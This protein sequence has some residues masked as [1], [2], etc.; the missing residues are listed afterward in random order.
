MVARRVIKV[1]LG[2]RTYDSAIDVPRKSFAK[3]E[4]SSFES[5]GDDVTICLARQ[6]VTLW[7]LANVRIAMVAVAACRL[8]SIRDDADGPRLSTLGRG[9]NIKGDSMTRTLRTLM[10]VCLGAF[11]LTGVACEDLQTKSALNA[12]KTELG[13]EQ[14]KGVD[15]QAALEAMKAQLAQ[16]AAKIDGLNRA[17]EA[18]KVAVKDEKPAEEKGKAVDAKKV[19]E[20]KKDAAKPAAPAK[21]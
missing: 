12:C 2:V 11:I 3:D 14:K 21:Q 13:N 6:V 5:S 16:A 20:P 4:R 9:E 8:L 15:Q 7:L 18:A 1:L 10:T 19:A 17:A